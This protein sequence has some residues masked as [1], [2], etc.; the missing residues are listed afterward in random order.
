MH[1]THI[2]MTVLIS[3]TGH[4]A[5]VDNYKLLFLLGIYIFFVVSYSEFTL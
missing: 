4:G 5:M 3:V 2:A 1:I